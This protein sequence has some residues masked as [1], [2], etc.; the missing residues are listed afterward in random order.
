MDLRWGP[1]LTYLNWFIVLSIQKK[2]QINFKIITTEY[3]DFG[4]S[5][6]DQSQQ[7]FLIDFEKFDFIANFTRALWWFPC[8][9]FH[10]VSGYC[11][12]NFEYGGNV[13][14]ELWTMSP[15][16]ILVV[17][18]NNKTTSTIPPPYGSIKQSVCLFICTI[19]AVCVFRLYISYLL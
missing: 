15:S 10:L 2:I 18:T 7:I 1:Y 5:I 13:V 6:E 3:G 12:H 11:L 8:W 16:P 17:T 4:L 14:G 19:F 9:T